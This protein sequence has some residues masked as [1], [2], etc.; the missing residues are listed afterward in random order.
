VIATAAIQ[1][2]FGARLASVYAPAIIASFGSGN[3]RIDI[4]LVFPGGTASYRTG[5]QAALRAR[6]A[7]GAELLANSQIA[8][9]ATARAQLLSGDVDPR[10]PMLLVAMAGSHPVR[11]VDFVN[12][13]PGGGPASLLRSVD[14]ATADGAAHL[15]RA[16]Y[17]DWMQTFID[18]QTAQYLPSWAQEV[19]LRS[20]Q[21]VLRIG[22]G[23]PSPLSPLS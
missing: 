11:I 6:K 13:S 19:T 2:Q 5:E 8:V 21:A 9:S 1:A 15:T 17:L 10:L 22:Y 12:Q 18:A 4:L 7:A 14:V 23:A 16:A 3:A 20:S